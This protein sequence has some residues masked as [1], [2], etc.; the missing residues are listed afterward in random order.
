MILM[1][2]TLCARVAFEIESALF[3]RLQLY[4]HFCRQFDF[5][6][7]AEHIFD[8]IMSSSPSG[9]KRKRNVVSIETKLEII[10]ELKKGAT[11]VALNT[12]YGM[13]RQTISDLKKNADEIE[14]F[15]SQMESL[16]IGKKKR[17][18][19][20]KSPHEVL[21]TALYVWFVQKRSEGIP[22]SGPLICEKAL[23]FNSKLNGD[24]NFKAS[25]GWLHNFKSRHGIR[26]LNIEGEK[27]SAASAEAVAEYRTKFLELIEENGLSRDQVYN[28]DETGL[29]YK[30][31]PTKTLA[32]NVICDRKICHRERFFCL[33]MHRATQKPVN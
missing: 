18:T 21:D 7:C 28:A 26:E 5:V 29:N 8:L 31:I 24:A 14:K 13:P 16:D 3:C 12:K 20:K 11:T 2:F 6:F 23:F 19:M 17:K 25:A 30:A 32:S 10:K 27:L 33:T 1:K 15:A 9:S 4:A 22:L